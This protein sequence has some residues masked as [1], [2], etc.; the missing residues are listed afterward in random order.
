MGVQIDACAGVLNTN[1]P[2]GVRGAVRSRSQAMNG[3]YSL[4]T[5]YTYSPILAIAKQ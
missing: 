4:L 3:S 5:G 1:A 2:D